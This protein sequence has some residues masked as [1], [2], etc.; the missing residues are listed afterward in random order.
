MGGSGLYLRIGL[1]VIGGAVLLIAL[2]WFLGG[3]QLSHGILFE[4]YFSESVQGLEVGAP[5]KYRGVTLG[6][7]TD[8]GLVSAEYGLG[9]PV[10]LDSETYQLVFVRCIV[11]A[12]KLGRVPGTEEAVNSGLRARLASQGLT[13]LT[14][15]E[16]DFVNPKEYPPLAVPWTPKAPYIPSMPST[17][18]QVQDAAQLLLSKLNHID[19]NQLA[20][21]FTG[22]AS[23]LRTNLSSG[24]IHHTLQTAQDAIREAD[25][26]GLSAELKRTSTSLRD[27]LQNPNT[28]KL[29]G[30]AALAAER[31]ANAADRL[32]PLIAAIQATSRRADNSVADVQQSLIPVL[33]DIQATAANL[34]EVTAA[35]RGSP[36][37]TIFGSP[38]PHARE[39]VR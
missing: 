38:P 18:A 19:L 3:A 24:D 15:I 22:L 25:L 16:L 17:L 23:D 13:G 9:E 26:P 6:R 4:S 36:A 35:L 34:R 10:N 20:T 21:E 12:D 28:Q 27:V 37:Q 5:V 32:P 7:V 29:L 33:R 8:I 11:D 1:L 39:P 31:F 30:N 14:Y 2:I